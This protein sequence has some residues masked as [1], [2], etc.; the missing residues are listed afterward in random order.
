MSPSARSPLPGAALSGRGPPAAPARVWSPADG[1]ARPP[2]LHRPSSVPRGRAALCDWAG[3]AATRRGLSGLHLLSRSPE[4]TSLKMMEKT[5]KYWLTKG[6]RGGFGRS[7]TAKL[8]VTSSEDVRACGG[9]A[10]RF[11]KTCGRSG[12]RRA[13]RRYPKA[14]GGGGGTP[15]KEDGRWGM[16]LPRASRSLSSLSLSSCGSGSPSEKNDSPKMCVS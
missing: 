1:R 6:V 4:E 13:A 16:I 3:G 14:S 15:R 5:M 8:L 11:R 9:W 10:L 7:E 2:I 12:V